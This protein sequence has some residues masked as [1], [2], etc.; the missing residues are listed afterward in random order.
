MTRLNLF[1]I[2]FLKNLTDHSNLV[3]NKTRVQ[4]QIISTNNRNR[5]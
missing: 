4:T 1:L 3:T 5:R 2:I